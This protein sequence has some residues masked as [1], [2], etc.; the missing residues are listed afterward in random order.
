ME[1]SV[2]SFFLPSNNELTSEVASKDL[3]VWFLNFDWTYEK[4]N[5]FAL[6][7]TFDLTCLLNAEL[8]KL[9]SRVPEIRSGVFGTGDQMLQEIDETYPFTHAR[10][11]YH[12]PMHFNNF[13]SGSFVWF[14]LLPKI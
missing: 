11:A 1:A 8:N 12:H 13:N 3:S 4:L 5:N 10:M 14:S 7:Q 9:V 6:L 2:H